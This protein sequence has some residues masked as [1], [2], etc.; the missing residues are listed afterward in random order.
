MTVS[1]PAALYDV[2]IVG[3][4]PAGATCAWYLARQG[5]RVLLLD[6][7]R[8]PR[9]KLC[10]DAVTAGAQVHLDRMGVLPAVLAAQ[11]GL[12]AAAVASSVR[13]APAPW[14]ARRRG[15]AGPS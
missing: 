11:E 3:A 2:C 7:A 1:R 15:T 5:R 13:A 9:D 10:G 6:K 12:G 8:F 14:G 4:G